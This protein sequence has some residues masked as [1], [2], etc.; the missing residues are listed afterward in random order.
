MAARSTNGMPAA[1]RWPKGVRLLVFY[2]VAA[3]LWAGACAQL[4]SA[5]GI[6]ANEWVGTWATALNGSDSNRSFTR[7][8]LRQIV[9]TSI[10]GSTARIQISN[11]FGTSSLRIE[12]VHIA[13][14]QG[15]S[16]IVPASDRKLH[17]GRQ[18][19]ATVAPGDSVTGDT[20]DFQ[21]PPLGDVVISMYLP[22]PITS[23]TYHA[24]AH[25]T[26]YVAN[27]DV[28]GS[29]SLTNP[30]TTGS[31]YFLTNLDVQ[32]KGLQGAVV[33]LGAS[34]TEG[35]L[36]TDN[37]NRRWP[38]NLAR[39]LADAGIP[40]GVLNMGISGNRLLSSGAGPSIENRFERDVLEQPGVHWVIFSDDPINDLGDKTNV[41]TAEALIG[42][43]K[44]IILR[45]HSK[46][47]RFL[48]STLT[49]Y[50]GA[51]SWNQSTETE[52]ERVNAY[53]RSEK[54]GCDAIVDQD[55]GTHDPENPSRFWPAYDA[56]DH[57]HPNDAG[58]EAIARVV[59]LDDLSGKKRATQNK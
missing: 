22:G 49:P 29:E 3:A 35:Y 37:K 1:T 56:G 9:H 10:G 57:L 32:G 25:Q 14:W 55:T 8:T 18:D 38:D 43:Y 41:P 31:W 12:D 4:R 46:G 53:L 13:L 40:V 48:C 24:S 2:G 52:R 45:A 11:L 21:V 44:R 5:P 26:S 23:A 39:R 50:E 51:S 33:T 27:G 19:A 20:V 42:G 58:F 59:K 34:I 17:F 30:T 16:A 36:G 54:S 15:G 47:I 6:P 7:Q 28:S